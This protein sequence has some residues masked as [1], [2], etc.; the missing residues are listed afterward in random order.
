VEP[1]LGALTG[2]PSELHGLERNVAWRHFTKASG[3]IAFDEAHAEEFSSDLVAIFA[4]RSRYPRDPGLTTLVSRLR[5]ESPDSDVAGARR[6]SRVTGRATKT[7]TAPR[8]VP[9]AI[10]CDVLTAPA[11]TC[12][13]SST[14][15]PCPGRG[16]LQTRAARVGRHQ[17]L[18]F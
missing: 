16:R 13:S 2:D 14:T 1:A 4:R 17:A 6:T 8:S 15:R 9:I 18:T 3:L 12:A 5:A 10:D 7:A 11:P